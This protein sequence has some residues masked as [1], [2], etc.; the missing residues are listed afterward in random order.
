MHKGYISTFGE[1]N[2]EN[3]T[4][5]LKMVLG[6]NRIAV[7]FKRENKDDPTHI[8][9]IKDNKDLWQAHTGTIKLSDAIMKETDNELIFEGLIVEGNKEGKFKMVLHINRVPKDITKQQAIAAGKKE[10]VERG[11]YCVCYHC[12]SQFRPETITI[13]DS[14]DYACCP[15]CGVDAVIGSEVAGKCSMYTFMELHRE[16]WGKIDTS[17]L[18][19]K[20]FKDNG[21]VKDDWFRDLDKLGG[22]DENSN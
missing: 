8:V 14:A 1:G 12:F 10:V 15:K 6:E 2:D 18:D 5:I 16:S 9:L 17:E 7:D 13:W 20:Y 19:K 4:H 11:G 21:S 22:G 3:R